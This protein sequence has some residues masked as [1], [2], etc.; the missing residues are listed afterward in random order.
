MKYKL[1]KVVM[2]EKIATHRFKWNL[3][4]NDIDKSE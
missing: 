4:A 3:C 1:Y 2:Q